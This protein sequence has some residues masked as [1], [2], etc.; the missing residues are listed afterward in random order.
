MSRTQLRALSVAELS[1]ALNKL[2]AALPNLDE[3]ADF[4][5]E[6]CRESLMWVTFMWK[7]S[8]MHSRSLGITIAALTAFRSHLTGNALEEMPVSV[9]FDPD[10]VPTPALCKIKGLQVP[11]QQVIYKI[12]DIQS[13]VAWLNIVVSAG[14]GG[15]LE[16]AF[17]GAY[18]ILADSLNHLEVYC[19]CKTNVQ[20]FRSELD[21][22]IA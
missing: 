2:V 7:D 17:S 10:A 6:C 22:L 5:L 8:L 14:M 20:E 19:H 3:H 1:D 18:C 15:R 13:S 9:Q 21:L 4:E 11:I 16:A 12:S